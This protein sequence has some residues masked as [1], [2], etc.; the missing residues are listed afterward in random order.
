MF[1]NRLTCRK[2]FDRRTYRTV[3]RMASSVIGKSGRV[4]VPEKVLQRQR[5]AK[6]SVMKAEY[7]PD[8][9]QRQHA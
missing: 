4:Y 3:I 5:E 9:I 1:L 7:V 8:K 2:S 6:L